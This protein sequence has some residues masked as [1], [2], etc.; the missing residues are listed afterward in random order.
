MEKIK[1]TF[2]GV[3]KN[4]HHLASGVACTSQW[5][6]RSSEM[7][8]E[9]PLPRGG[10]QSQPAGGCCCCNRPAAAARGVR[11]RAPPR[12][13]VPREGGL[14]RAARQQGGRDADPAGRP[15][16]APGRG[17][18]AP[19]LRR[20]AGPRPRRGRRGRRRGL[21]RLRQGLVREDVDAERAVGRRGR[22]GGQLADVETTTSD[23]R[24]D[25]RARQRTR[26]RR[27]ANTQALTTA[28]RRLAN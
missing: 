20:P 26:S 24:R 11:G 15:A 14:G 8:S 18:G 25:S 13:G 3:I 5:A 10:S 21:G 22:H 4:V 17:R 7:S 28:T 27:R 23:Y 6:G 2:A 16:R 12:G 1:K 9:M 19:A